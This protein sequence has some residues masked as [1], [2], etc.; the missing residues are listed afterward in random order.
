[1]IR[2][3]KIYLIPLLVLTF[4]AVNLTMYVGYVYFQ[5]QNLMNK[6]P[7]DISG[8]SKN[9]SKNIGQ[10]A[11]KGELLRD[12]PSDS[13]DKSKDEHQE[14]LKENLRDTAIVFIGRD[15]N[16]SPTV[17]NIIGVETM[18]FINE[19]DVPH[20]VKIKNDKEFTLKPNIPLSIK[21]TE[22]QKER[23]YS[24]SCDTKELAGYF[25]IPQ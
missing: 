18:K 25:Y 7:Q 15:C 12:I 23:F 10:E 24:Y 13:T 6:N 5:K 17:A 21:V 8:K 1:M 16:S 19:S 14:F 11:P 2:V 3:K 20:T 4:I 9:V 22:F